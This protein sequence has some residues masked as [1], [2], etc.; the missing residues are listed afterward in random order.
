MLLLLL[1]Q[2]ELL[3]IDRTPCISY[4]R[5]MLPSAQAIRDL[6]GVPTEVLLQAFADRVLVL[7]TQLGKVGNLIQATI[8]PTTDLLPP[9]PPDPTQPNLIPLPEPPSAIELTPLLGGPPSDH[10]QTLHSL[11]A[12]QIATLVW[13][14][15]EEGQ[16]EGERRAVVVGIALRKPATQNGGVGFDEHEK[17]VFHGVM[18]MV[19]E[20]L[21]R[22]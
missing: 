14:S 6:D 5:N 10:L 13:T 3:D 9:P 12:S 17:A 19:R 8:P 21:R 7:V 2:E 16:L 11:Y 18:D 4:F 22:Q 15:E 1:T 20:L